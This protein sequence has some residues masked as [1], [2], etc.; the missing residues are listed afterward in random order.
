MTKDD[1]KLIL[2]AFYNV[3]AV[4]RTSYDAHH[5]F[6]YAVTDEYFDKILKEYNKLKEAEK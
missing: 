4:I 1:I 3:N 2:K 5:A 6:E